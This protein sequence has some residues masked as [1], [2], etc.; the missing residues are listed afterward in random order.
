[1]SNDV[2]TRVALI[3]VTQRHHADELDRLRSDIATTADKL[4]SIERQLSQIKWIAV[5]AFGTWVTSEVGIFNVVKSL[6]LG[7]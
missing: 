3:E 7:G 4:D 5:G 2:A 1:M 6:W